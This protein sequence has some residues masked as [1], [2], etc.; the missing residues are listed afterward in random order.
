[1]YGNKHAVDLDMHTCTYKRWQL[2]G[3]LCV[4]AICAILAKK[5]E[6]SLFVDNFLLPSTY[7]DAYNPIIYHIIG[8]DDWEPMDYSIAPPPYKKQAGKPK[9][10]RTKEPGER[11]APPAPDATK[12][13]ENLYICKQNGHNKKGCPTIKNHSSEESYKGGKA[14]KKQHAKRA[15]IPKRPKNV[16]RQTI[17][18]RSVWKKRK[19]AAGTNSSGT[20]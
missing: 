17:T 6:P 1:M 2:S 10:K 9:M 12:M 3:I 19:Q 15:V 11:K 7:L 14:P 5:F 18:S 4:H 13:P 16:V 20:A 8:D